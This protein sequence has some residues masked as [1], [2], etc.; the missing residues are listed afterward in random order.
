MKAVGV[1]FV[2]VIVAAY[3]TVDYAVDDVVDPSSDVDV[4]SWEQDVESLMKG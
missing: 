3:S 1:V 2:D 4:L